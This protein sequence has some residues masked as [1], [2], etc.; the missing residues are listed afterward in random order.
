MITK[1]QLGI[2][3]I[4]LALAA[5]AGITVLEWLGAGSFEGIGPLQRLAY[6]ASGLTLLIGLSLLPLGDRPA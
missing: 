5:L 4:L 6:L 2:G 1:R 3:L